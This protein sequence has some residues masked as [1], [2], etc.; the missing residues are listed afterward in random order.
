MVMSFVMILLAM[1]TAITE[2]TREIGILKS[3]GA[4][5]TFIL[6]LI[7]SESLLLS[8]LGVVLGFLLTWISLK[9]ISAEFPT[10]P[11]EISMGWR[12]LAALTAV[13]GGILGSL[14][15]AIKA[16]QLDPVQA[17]DYE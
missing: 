15:P 7:L 13:V 2:R 12:A 8:V 4:S 14:Y 5:K 17:L 6:N 16:S 10:L 3:L 1:Y 9:L 11:I